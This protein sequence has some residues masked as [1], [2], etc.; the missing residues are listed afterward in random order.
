MTDKGHVWVL[1]TYKSE[2]NHAETDKGHVSIL[3]N[4]KSGA[5]DTLNL[6]KDMCG[7]YS[8]ESLKPKAH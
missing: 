5:K 3:L 4:Y 8:F 1:L 6:T 2:A 7:S